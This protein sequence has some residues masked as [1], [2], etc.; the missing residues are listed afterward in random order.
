LLLSEAGKAFL[1]GTDLH[2]VRR[3]MGGMEPDTTLGHAAGI[4]A[5]KL[6]PAA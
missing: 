4:V 5:V 2:T 6:R 3:S 1:C